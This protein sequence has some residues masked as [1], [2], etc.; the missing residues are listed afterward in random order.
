MYKRVLPRDAFNDANLL[1]CIGRLTMLIEDGFIPWLS[2]EYD[3]EAFNI[4]KDDSDGSIY[5]ANI[6]FFKTMPGG[7]KIEMLHFRPLNSQ[8]NWPLI[9]TVD[10]WDYYDVFSDKGEFILVMSSD[11]TLVE[12]EV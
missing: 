2:Y 9:L 6:R 7:D 10:G 5:V 11:G 8:D 3:G 4:H 12:Y 1:K